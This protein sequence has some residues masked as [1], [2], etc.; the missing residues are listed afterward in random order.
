LSWDQILEWLLKTVPSKDDFNANLLETGGTD[1]FCILL[2]LDQRSRYCT[3]FGIAVNEPQESM[4]IKQRVHSIYP[5]KSSI[6]ASKSSV[7]FHHALCATECWFGL[8][9][10]YRRQFNDWKAVPRNNH[11]LTACRVLNEL[12]K[13]LLRLFDRHRR[14]AYTSYCMLHY[15]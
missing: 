11:M 13:I 12:R 1:E 4:G 3:E 7:I 14:H 10:H 5:R 15:H 8:E 2:V 9:L 6:G